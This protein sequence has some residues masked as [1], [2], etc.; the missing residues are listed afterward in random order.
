MKSYYMK[1]LTAALSASMVLSVTAGITACNKEADKNDPDRSHSGMKISDSSPW[2]EAKEF[3]VDL[4]L[5]E[6]RDIDISTSK[7]IGC[8]D[9]YIYIE[10]SCEYSHPGK[11]YFTG[12]DTAENVSVVDRNTGETVKIIDM[13]ELL[14]M[15]NYINNVKF[16][17]GVLEISSTFWY[18]DGTPAGNECWYERVE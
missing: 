16:R 8:D 9:K 12:E 5:E 2:Y 15:E 6:G 10:T 4:G 17:N 11:Y 14:G 7:F 13:L 3:K 18:P 1:L